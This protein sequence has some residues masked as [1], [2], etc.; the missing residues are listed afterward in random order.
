[1]DP[2]PPMIGKTSHSSIS[3]HQI[4]NW[5]WA[6]AEV[7]VQVWDRRGAH[8]RRYPGPWQP[9]PWEITQASVSGG[10]LKWRLLWSL[11]TGDR[12]SQTW[13]MNSR[14]RWPTLR[15]RRRSYRISWCLNTGRDSSLRTWNI[16][17]RICTITT[18]SWRLTSITPR[19]TIWGWRH[20]CPS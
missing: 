2:V 18:C 10:G 9:S 16:R 1:M 17:R 13:F 5:F 15:G 3:H 4:S 19:K 20:G 6:V 7:A 12:F 14:L 8:Q 11:M